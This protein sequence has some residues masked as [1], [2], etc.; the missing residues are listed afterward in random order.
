MLLPV[1]LAAALAAVA[2]KAAATAA[3]SFQR[4]LA[5]P[6]QLGASRIGTGSQGQRSRPPERQLISACCR[7]WQLH[8]VGRQRGAAA[9][10]EQIRQVLL[11]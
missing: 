7:L 1:L 10:P 8:G 4:C 11:P 3:P 5:I 6:S 2:H 9:Q